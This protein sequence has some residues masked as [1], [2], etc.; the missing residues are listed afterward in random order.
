MV[1]EDYKND[2]WG[3]SKQGFEDMYKILSTLVFTNETYNI[4]EFGSGISTKFFVDFANDGDKNIIIYSFDDSIEFSTRIVDSK[5]TFKVKKLLTCN[6]ASY[7]EMFN[8]KKYDRNKM[9]ESPAP[10]SRQK[11]CFYD[12]DTYDL[13]EVINFLFIDGPHGN[14]R[15]FAFLHSLNKLKS[16]SIVFIDDYDHYNFVSTLESLFKVQILYQVN[17][18]SDNKWDDGGSYAIYRVI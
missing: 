5:L 14:G 2:G 11:N 15:N 7:N 6:D 8:N 13:P 9:I 1:I 10:T 16:G 18:K 17:V 4:V 12:I 3:I